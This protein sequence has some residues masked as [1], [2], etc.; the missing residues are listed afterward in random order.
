MA[1]KALV[2][3]CALALS[4]LGIAQIPIPEHDNPTCG[5]VRESHPSW[6]TP[7]LV[8]RF[9]GRLPLPEPA[10]DLCA[11]YTK[12][13]WDRTM[14]LR[15]GEGAEEYRSLIELAVKTWNEVLLGFN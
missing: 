7:P 10:T 9:Q 12:A 14:K 6:S 4:S 5:G 8:P 11:Q 13:G 15:L 1:L 3:I 2:P